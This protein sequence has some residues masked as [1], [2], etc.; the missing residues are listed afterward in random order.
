VYAEPALGRS[1]SIASTRRPAAT[2]STSCRERQA[3]SNGPAAYSLCADEQ[4]GRGS[5]D[6][7]ARDTSNLH[8]VRGYNALICLHYC[9]VAR[10]A[11]MRSTH[12]QYRGR[13]AVAAFVFAGA[14]PQPEGED[15]RSENG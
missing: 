12:C 14:Q 5:A 9:G 3:R 13:E 15:A 6:P 10:F 4:T 8:R 7:L 1:R 2:G 11:S